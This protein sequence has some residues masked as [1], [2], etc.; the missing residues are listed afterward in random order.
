MLGDADAVDTD[1]TKDAEG[2]T[3]EKKKSVGRP[4]LHPLPEEIAPPKYVTING[5]TYTLFGP[6]G[7]SLPK[8]AWDDGCLC[9][10]GDTFGGAIVLLCEQCD[11]EYH[12]RIARFPNPGTHVIADCPPVIT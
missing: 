10:G 2:D 1:D 5:G 7:S 12:V 3:K 8:V 4:R 9:C 6:R 11:G